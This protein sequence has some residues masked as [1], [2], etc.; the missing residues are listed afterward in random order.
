MCKQRP[1]FQENAALCDQVSEIQSDIVTAKEER[2]ILIRRLMEYHPEFEIIDSFEKKTTKRKNSSDSVGKTTKESSKA[3]R[4][5]GES[6][7]PAKQKQELIPPPAQQNEVNLPLFQSGQFAVEEVEIPY[8]TQP[9]ENQY[10][11]GN[12]IIQSLGEIHPNRFNYHNEHFIYP[13]GF[14]S[15]RIFASLGDPFKKSIYTCRIVDG[16]D[17]PRFEMISEA[18]PEIMIVGP[19]TDFCHYTLLQYIK[20]TFG[21]ENFD[22]QSN[23]DWFFGLAHPAVMNLFRD[24]PNFN[25]CHRFKGFIKLEDETLALESDPSINFQAFHSYITMCSPFNDPGA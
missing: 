19:S 10:V 12:L 24:M 1:I 9:N 20:E 25:A 6:N 21:F 15:V 22:L 2:R 11:I 7:K 8:E 16:G 14:A 18:D 4:N 5:A 23:G 13:I 3:G 17:C